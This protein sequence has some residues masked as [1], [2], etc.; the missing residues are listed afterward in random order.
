MTKA[1]LP[2]RLPKEDQELLATRFRIRDP[3]NLTDLRQSVPLDVAMTE[4]LQAY[5]L[6]NGPRSAWPRCC[7]CKQKTRHLHGYVVAFS[8]EQ[9]GL[10]GHDCGREKHGLDY[11]SMI[12]RFAVDAARAGLLRQGIKLF[13]CAAELR[14]FSHEVRT[15]P[16]LTRMQ[17]FHGELRREMTRFYARFQQATNGRVLG[18]RR[19]ADYEAMKNRDSRL[20]AKLGRMARGRGMNEDTS[21]GELLAELKA[22]R[23]PDASKAPIY[24]EVEAV[25]HQ[26]KGSSFFGTVMVGTRLQRIEHAATIILAEIEQASRERLTNARLR[27]SVAAMTR[28]IEEASRL[29]R[30]VLDA[31][32]FFAPGVIPGLVKVWNRLHK[33]TA[34]GPA[35]LHGQA[36]TYVTPAGSRPVRVPTL[37]SAAIPDT[38][39]RLLR[40]LTEV[41]AEEA[42]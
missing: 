28:Q 20:D 18:K 41:F 5:N 38:P 27:A 4:V 2:F 26:F 13:D 3:R 40:E 30:D 14:T 33:T 35:A 37:P 15:D 9:I 17:A 11:A 12:D 36:L 32:A 10:L 1:R 42:I 21:R 22:A 16:A 23:D 25:I 29:R 8:D 19:Q 6:P 39:S 31:Q 7:T 34:P 24:E